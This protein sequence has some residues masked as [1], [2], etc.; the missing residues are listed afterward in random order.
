MIHISS[1][2]NKLADQITPENLEIINL[3]FNNHTDMLRKAISEVE[4]RNMFN[5]EH[6]K[7][8]MDDREA[9]YNHLFKTKFGIF[10]NLFFNTDEQTATII[11]KNIKIEFSLL[12]FIL[13]S[14][15]FIL[16]KE[17]GNYT[18]KNSV[19]SDEVII[20]KKETKGNN[21]SYK[22]I[23][24]ICIDR[25]KHHIPNTPINDYIFNSILSNIPM[26]EIKQQLSL[27]NSA[28]IQSHNIDM[29]SFIDNLQYLHESIE[30]KEPHIHLVNTIRKL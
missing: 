27:F 20:L 5:K 28:D 2:Y 29:E 19:R 14:P 23:Y 22:Q 13:N 12:D 7:F 4:T 18:F 1:I 24:A 11:N 9:A 26:N 6:F 8:N 30:K 10:R 17:I 25:D 16:E 21:D 15:T 3:L